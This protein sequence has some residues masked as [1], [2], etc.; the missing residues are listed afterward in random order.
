MALRGLSWLG[1]GG[2]ITFPKSGLAQTMKEVGAE[3][4]VLETDAPYLAPVPHRGKRNESSYI[5][6]IAQALAT[7]TG[8]TLDDIEGITT[9][10][11]TQLFAR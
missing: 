8:R 11:A 10:N 1:I 4:C 5:P 7:A 6:L 3:Y 9:A 2:V